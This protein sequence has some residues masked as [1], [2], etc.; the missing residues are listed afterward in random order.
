MY[1]TLTTMSILFYSDSI[2]MSEDFQINTVVCNK[3]RSDYALMAFVAGS[4]ICKSYVRLK[5]LLV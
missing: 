3:F 4:K 2:E 5:G 1:S